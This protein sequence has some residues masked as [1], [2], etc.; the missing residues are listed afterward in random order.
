LQ[1]DGNLV[2]YQ[3]NRATWASNTSGY[4]GANLRATLNS[5]LA[6]IPDP[7]TG[8]GGK[9]APEPTIACLLNPLVYRGN[10]YFIYPGDNTPYF[11]VIMTSG[12]S[13]TTGTVISPSNSEC[14]F[15]FDTDGNI[16]VYG[17]RTP[18]GWALLFSTTLPPNS[19][20]TLYM[21]PDGNLVINNNGIGLA[22]AAG[23]GDHPGGYPG[24]VLMMNKETGVLVV[25]QLASSIIEYGAWQSKVNLGYNY[26]PPLG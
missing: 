19:A 8:I 25:W 21:Q 15:H 7:G 17:P 4:R 23:L 24:A 22:W 18:N 9:S 16:R 10:S 5:R 26:L 11:D 3:G 1:T 13:I 6:I 20:R 12:Q 2:L 14:F